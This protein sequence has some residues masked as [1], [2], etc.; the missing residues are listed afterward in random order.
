MIFSGFDF[1]FFGWFSFGSVGG[2]WLLGGFGSFFVVCE[3]VRL[4]GW[5]VC[6]LT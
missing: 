5:L 1:R 4:V 3:F 2:F 6:F